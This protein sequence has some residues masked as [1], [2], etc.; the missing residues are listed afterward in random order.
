MTPISGGEIRGDNDGGGEGRK[1]AL[2]S[3]QLNIDEAATPQQRRKVS[4]PVVDTMPVVNTMPRTVSLANR[5]KDLA[6]ELDV[7]TV[8]A[9]HMLAKAI[10]CFA[11]TA[12]HMDLQSR[13]AISQNINSMLDL[14]VGGSLSSNSILRLKMPQSGDKVKTVAFI[15]R[16]ITYVANMV[17]VSV[18]LDGAP[19]THSLF[20]TQ[21][22]KEYHSWVMDDF[23]PECKRLLSSA[24]YQRSL[25]D[26]GDNPLEDAITS[27]CLE[28][29]EPLPMKL[30]VCDKC[31]GRI[32]EGGGLQCVQCEAKRCIPCFGI[33]PGIRPRSGE[34]VREYRCEWCLE[35]RKCNCE[36][37]SCKPC[38]TLLWPDIC[39]TLCSCCGCDLKDV[40]AAA[41]PARCRHCRRLFC[42]KEVPTCFV[43]CQNKASSV[44]FI[45][46]S[47]RSKIPADKQP[48]ETIRQVALI[49]CVFCTG[50]E[51]FLNSREDVF[52]SMVRNVFPGIRD[53]L[54]MSSDVEIR[55]DEIQRSTS[56]TV[57]TREP[58]RQPSS[59]QHLA[60]FVNDMQCAGFIEFSTKA[61]PFLLRV[62]SAQVMAAPGLKKLPSCVSPFNMLHILDQHPQANHK[63]LEQVC[64]AEASSAAKL[65]DEIIEQTHA[66]GHELVP[67]QPFQ[68]DGIKRV[69]FYGEDLFKVGPLNDLVADTII[70]F[71]KELKGRCDVLVFGVG[72]DYTKD[73][74]HPPLK[75]LWEHFQ[76]EYRIC[77]DQ[78]EATVDKFRKIRQSKLDVFVCLSGYTGSG[79]A[80]QML[81]RRVAQV[82]MNWLEFAS[83]LYDPELV[84]FTIVGQAVGDEQRSCI[85][86]ERLA[87]IN[88]PGTYQPVQ[89]FALLDQVHSRPVKKDRACWGLPAD[90]F[91]IL[92]LGTTNRLDF[93]NRRVH[94]FWEMGRQIPDSIFLFPDKPAAA[95]GY[96]FLSL[97]DY[98]ASQTEDRRKVDPSRLVFFPLNPLMEK[99]DLWELIVAAGHEGGRGITFGSAVCLD[100]AVSDSLMNCVPHFTDRNPKGSMQ[101]RVASEILTAAGIE[102]ECVGESTDDT[103]KKVVRYA[104]D[105]DMQDRMIGHL[106]LSRTDKVGF[107]DVMRA[108]RMLIYAVDHAY[109]LVK[110]AEKDRKQL[111]DFQ[112]PFQGH[113]MEA[114]GRELTTSGGSNRFKLLNEARMPVELIQ[115]AADM[116]EAMERQGGEL[117]KVQ[118]TGSYTVAILAKFTSVSKAQVIKLSLS[119]VF[120]EQVHNNPLFREAK[121]LSEWDTRRN[122]FLGLLPKPGKV[123][124]DGVFFGHSRPNDDGLVVP[125]LICEYIPRG[126]VEMATPHRLDWQERR[127]LHDSLRVILIQ[128]FSSGI[129]WFQN[130]NRVML[131][132]RDLKP[133]NVRFRED[134][135]M[136]VVD[137][138]SSA[139]FSVAGK[140]TGLRRM[141]STVVRHPTPMGQQAQQ[142]GSGLLRGRSR[143]GAYVG[144][145]VE[146]IQEFCQCRQVRGSGLALIGGTTRGF[147]SARL[148]EKQRKE[149]LRH[150]LAIPRFDA[151]LGCKQDTFA[152]FR[153]VLHMLTR[154]PNQSIETWIEKADQ[155]I[156]GGVDGIKRMLLGAGSGG[157]D[158]QQ[159]LAFER[160]ADFL[161][162]GQRGL[163]MMRTVTHEFPTLAILTPS[164]ERDFSGP[165]G[166]QFPH[167]PVPST[168]P[169]GFLKSWSASVRKKV[170]KHEIPKQTF[171]GQQGMGGGVKALEDVAGNALLGVYVG[172]RVRNNICG[173][174]YDAPNFPSRFNVTGQGNLKILQQIRDSKFTCDAQ[175]DLVH[176]FE[177]CR[178]INNSGPFMNAAASPGEANCIVDRYSAWYDETT[179]LIWML[180]WANPDGIKKGEYCIWYY[181]YQDGAGQLWNFDE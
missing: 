173:T 1:R 32:S 18:L 81:Y 135:T 19:Y 109:Q 5:V 82:Q 69:G 77:F 169:A 164:Q 150:K 41:Y 89:S 74:I 151:D 35:K 66:S 120:P 40:H 180:V 149:R 80:A 143:H 42:E 75:E 132:V 87:V 155:A 12:Q 72:S 168:W 178:T 51:L 130:N 13:K 39:A 91:I 176:D 98:N 159:P 105:R 114:L 103:V 118:G 133:D 121:G 2:D 7:S 172:K 64:A 43:D 57:V 8:Q 15:I 129:F 28:R 137:L 20:W 67:L 44:T 142:R 179:G 11:K 123:L 16:I 126:F 76:P 10:P 157:S 138:G 148:A 136:A 153:T 127:L 54:S 112:I 152:F 113:A 95:R 167:G 163:D 71:S 49:T 166:L 92:V 154:E 88:S 33:E 50:R 115:V 144:V 25:W 73:Q 47:A 4:V 141:V 27:F 117:L 36:L 58:R 139:T 53:P 145:T 106:N 3:A 181:K 174:L 158:P 22:K 119:G 97:A 68:E 162:R 85:K 177:W 140:N 102:S 38:R 70:R 17:A 147:F 65:G 93:T 62:V 116:L 107:Y 34:K 21:W 100:T 30:A 161:Y 146:D 110:A 165:G 111:K 170:Q 14:N 108:V 83:L 79:D 59:I 86:R 99:A 78:K 26:G 29:V 160:L 175:Q 55:R 6:Q 134:G 37:H 9:F 45:G 101:Q 96:I 31:A 48:L 63:M 124:Q 24:L 56:V 122:S 60:D 61:M 156:E 104:H 46:C 128:P 84:D 23:R 94:P 171:T 52:K 90:K 125:F 131:V